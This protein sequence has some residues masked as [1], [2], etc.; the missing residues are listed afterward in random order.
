MT[1]SKFVMD[2]LLTPLPGSP[3]LWEW[4]CVGYEKNGRWSFCNFKLNKWAGIATII[5]YFIFYD[6]KEGFSFQFLPVRIEILYR[7]CRGWVQVHLGPFWSHHQVEFLVIPRF[8]EYDI[9][10]I[11]TGC[12]FFQKAYF[13]NYGSIGPGFLN[14]HSFVVGDCVSCLLKHPNCEPIDIFCCRNGKF[15]RVTCG[16]GRLEIFCSDPH[17]GLIRVVRCPCAC[18]PTEEN[19]DED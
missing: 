16:T 7:T 1:S 18:C 14:R 15:C 10:G 6:G 9:I 11:R 19:Q 3:V 17:C 4:N 5:L 13:C 2:N 8:L 12:G